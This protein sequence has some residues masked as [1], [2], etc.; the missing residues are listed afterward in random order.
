VRGLCRTRGT[1]S[2]ISEPPRIRRNSPKGELRMR[3]ASWKGSL[4]EEYNQR[5]RQGYLHQEIEKDPW[6][7]TRFRPA[8]GVRRSCRFPLETCQGS[9]RTRGS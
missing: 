3:P 9:R 6:N 2:C 8:E 7:L 5:G 4:R 1:T